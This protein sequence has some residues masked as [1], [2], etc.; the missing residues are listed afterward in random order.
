MTDIQRPRY[1]AFENVRGFVRF[2]L[3]ARGADDDPQST[4]GLANGLLK[5]LYRCLVAM[6]CALMHLHS[7]ALVFSSPGCSGTKSGRESCRPPTM[8]SHKP[9]VVSSSLLLNMESFSPASHSQL[10]PA[11][12]TNRVSCY[13]LSAFKVIAFRGVYDT[14]QIRCTFLCRRRLGTSR[15]GSGRSRMMTGPLMA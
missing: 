6:G 9:D 2:D 14:S 7:S 12:S 10:M 4:E 1:V 5:I 15:N 13:S 3:A 11:P 8:G